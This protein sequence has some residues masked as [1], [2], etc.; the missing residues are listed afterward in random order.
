MLLGTHFSVYSYFS[1]KIYHCLL[2]PI[3]LLEI[4]LS[5]HSLWLLSFFSGFLEIQILIFHLLWG[6]LSHFFFKYFHF[7][8]LSSWEYIRFS[9]ILPSLLYFPSPTPAFC[10]CNQMYIKCYINI[11][12]LCYQ[13]KVERFDR[14]LAFQILCCIRKNRY[15]SC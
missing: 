1:L 11:H 4:L 12:V 7:S 2:A 6:N 10:N 5:L 15:I 3:G 13:E 8:I 9:F 14:D